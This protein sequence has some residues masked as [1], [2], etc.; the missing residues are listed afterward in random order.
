[1]NILL[2]PTGPLRN[3]WLALY[4]TGG[5]YFAWNLAKLILSYVASSRWNFEEFDSWNSRGFQTWMDAQNSL[6][7]LSESGQMIFLLW[8]VSLIVWSFGAY[9]LTSTWA[10]SQ[11]R[12][13]R[14]W[15]IGGWFIP[16]GFLFI[17][18][19]VI[20]QT[21]RIVLSRTIGSIDGGGNRSIKANLLG[22]VWFISSWLVI[23]LNRASSSA[24]AE[25]A[26]F[27]R[28]YQF[29]IAASVLACCSVAVAL[30][31][32]S[33]ISEGVRAGSFTFES[34][35]SVA[36]ISINND[37]VESSDAERRRLYLEEKRQKK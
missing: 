35:S 22:P 32:F 34:Q 11:R 7:S 29:D 16:I 18:I 27:G 30:V 8:F 6:D 19:S 10:T 20:R 12:W 15:T 23:G 1:M 21:E 3:K 9:T 24:S 28:M 37:G 2:K 13:A 36:P 31:Y 17:P 25:I 26:T 4:I 33:G 5:I 14:G